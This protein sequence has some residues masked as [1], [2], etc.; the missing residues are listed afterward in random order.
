MTEAVKDLHLTLDAACP[1]CG[2]SVAGYESLPG[3]AYTS[4]H[5]GPFGG[6]GTVF[7]AGGD[8]HPVGPFDRM[9]SVRWLSRIDLKPCGCQLSAET[10]RMLARDGGVVFRIEGEQ[11][12]NPL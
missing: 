9:T 10:F 3:F 1:L 12:I 11:F 4:D 8:P 7:T 6:P 2:A 5:G